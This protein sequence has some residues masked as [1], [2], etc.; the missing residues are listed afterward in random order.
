MPR[1]FRRSDRLASQIQR[2]MADLIRIHVKD[3]ALGMVTVSDVEVSRDLAVAKV[4]VSFLGG[5]L[6]ANESVKHLAEYAPE[7]RRELGKRIHIRVL[8][9][10]RFLYDDSVERGMRMDALLDRLSHEPPKDGGEE[11]DS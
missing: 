7:L 1:E 6:P 4:Y 9:E 10:V 8:P 5:R 2:E 11:Q 3:S